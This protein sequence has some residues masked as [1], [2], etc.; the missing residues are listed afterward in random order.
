MI[1]LYYYNLY[2]TV[3]NNNSKQPRPEYKS[4]RCEVSD[5]FFV[6][7]DQMAGCQHILTGLG[8]LKKGL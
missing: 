4:D 6:V 2:F 5:R 8:Q 1:T 3:M 7:G